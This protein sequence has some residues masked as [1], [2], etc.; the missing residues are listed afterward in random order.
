MASVRVGSSEGGR[1]DRPR[2]RRLTAALA[3]SAPVW[4][5][6]AALA[7]LVAVVYL[8]FPSGTSVAPDTMAEATCNAGSVVR[9]EQALGL[10]VEPA[11]QRLALSVPS[12]PT[13]AN[14]AYG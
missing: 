1:I 10:V 2:A 11:L 7:A 3:G 13:A 6:E 4:S 12:V 8:A 14:L 9:F 5:I